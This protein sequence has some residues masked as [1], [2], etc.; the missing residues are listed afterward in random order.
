VKIGALIAIEQTIQLQETVESGIL[1]DCEAT[2]KC[3]RR[4]FSQQRHS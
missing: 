4:F 2:P 1:V 3:W